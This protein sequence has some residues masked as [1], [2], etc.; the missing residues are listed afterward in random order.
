MQKSSAPE[1]TIPPATTHALSNRPVGISALCI[2]LWAAAS[3]YGLYGALVVLLA[4]VTDQRFSYW[5]VTGIPGALL[6]SS[7]MLILLILTGLGLWQMKRI[8]VIL[9]AFLTPIGSVQSLL[10]DTESR[11]AGDTWGLL[12]RASLTLGLLFVMARLWNDLAVSPRMNKTGKP[13]LVHLLVLGAIPVTTW[14]AA[15]SPLWLNQCPHRLSDTAPVGLQPSPPFY[16][17]QPYDRIPFDSLYMPCG[18]NGLSLEEKER[19]AIRRQW[20]LELT[21]ASPA[22]KLESMLVPVI[23]RDV[24]YVLQPNRQTGPGDYFYYYVG[25]TLFYLPVERVMVTGDY[26]GVCPAPCR[27]QD[28]K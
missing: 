18:V 17:Q 16:S 26:L 2:L 20:I 27:W 28:E 1:L 22:S 10:L 7:A 19:A 3:L 11:P 23:R 5:Q 13:W 9:F 4:G 6:F 25:Y 24:D 14:L 21:N 15:A 8:G 12:A